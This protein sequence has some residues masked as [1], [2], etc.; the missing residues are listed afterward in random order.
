[1]TG[2]AVF[3]LPE[4][5]FLWVHDLTLNRMGPSVTA[6]GFDTEVVVS[7]ASV[8]GYL[9]APDPKD[10]ERAA[11]AGIDADAVAL[12]PLEVTVVAEDRLVAAGVDGWLDGTYRIRQVRETLTHL[13]LI[14]TRSV[15]TTPS[16]PDDNAIELIATAGSGD[17]VFPIPA[18]D[19]L[20]IHTLTVARQS[21]V[22]DVDSEGVWRQAEAVVRNTVVGYVTAPNARDQRI[23]ASPG[24]VLDAVAL[25]PRG[26][27]VVPDDT[28]IVAGV[29]SRMNGTYLVTAVR[30]NLSHLRV[31]LTRV[32]AP[33]P[34]WP[35]VLAGSGTYGFGLGPFGSGP[36]G[37]TP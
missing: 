35:P 16:W 29:S 22:V 17:A 3:P 31:L 19:F 2:D 36:F 32:T 37:G 28:L 5:T 4:P 1:V 15:G 30:P 9:T 14:L 12:V 33:V 8:V 34:T 7:A 26:I 10:I 20:F 23:A 18:P 11:S 21:V 13:R 24:Q 25:L 27:V 6:E